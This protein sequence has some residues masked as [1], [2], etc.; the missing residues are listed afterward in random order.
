MVL[1]WFENRTVNL[2]DLALFL[3]NIEFLV[4]DI[5]VKTGCVTEKR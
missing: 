4:E 5:G 3:L 2:I 1:D